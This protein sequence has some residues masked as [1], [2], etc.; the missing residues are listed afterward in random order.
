[1]KNLFL[2]K[3]FFEKFYSVNK[4]KLYLYLLWVLNSIK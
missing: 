3:L 2:F 1:M 4:E